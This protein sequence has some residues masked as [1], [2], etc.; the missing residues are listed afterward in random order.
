MD[1]IDLCSKGLLRPY[2]IDLAILDF[3]Q[4]VAPLLSLLGVFGILIGCY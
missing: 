3:E 1:G 2:T 4:Q